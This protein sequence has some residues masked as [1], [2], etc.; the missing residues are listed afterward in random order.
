MAVKPAVTRQFW[1]RY[2]RTASGHEDQFRP[3]RLNAR[4]RFGQGTFGGTHGNGET[5]SLR[6]RPR[7]LFD[8]KLTFAA[9][10]VR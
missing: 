1:S 10:T 2:E 4:C 8:P 3:R 9:V 6:L 5:R 7:G